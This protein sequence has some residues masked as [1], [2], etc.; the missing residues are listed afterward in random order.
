MA[1]LDP[2][3][4]FHPA[5][6]TR[7]DV[8]PDDDRMGSHSDGQEGTATG[9]GGGVGRAGCPEV[10]RCYSPIATP[11]RAVMTTSP[12]NK[13]RSLLE[14]FGVAMLVTRTADGQLRGRPMALAEVE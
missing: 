2:A 14:E 10:S 6:T 11:R 3:R 5:R 9:G 4:R 8:H 7:G 1:V 13:L 12:E